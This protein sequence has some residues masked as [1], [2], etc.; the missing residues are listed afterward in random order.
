M[1]T[2][3][4][5]AWESLNGKRVETEREATE[6]IKVQMNFRWPFRAAEGRRECGDGCKVDGKYRRGI[7][8]DFDQFG[9]VPKLS[10]ELSW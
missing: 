1:E 9:C 8:S 2:F 10:S 3:E 5:M 4:Q 7:G 6:Y